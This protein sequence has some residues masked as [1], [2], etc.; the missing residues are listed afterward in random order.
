MYNLLIVDDEN[1]ILDSYYELLYD[2]FKNELNIDKCSSSEQA[3]KKAENRIDIL[4]TDILMPRMNGYE[5]QKNITQIWPKCRIIFLTGNDNVNNAIKAIRSGR[6]MMDYIL[7]HEDDEMLVAAVTRAIDSLENEIVTSDLI[8]D[9]QKNILLALPVLRKEFMM[10]LL[11]SPAPTPEVIDNKLE[12]Y[13]IELS[14]KDRLILLCCAI[15]EAGS[16]LLPEDQTNHNAIFFAVDNIMK[17]YLSH[18][19]NSLGLT[20]DQNKMIWFIQAKEPFSKKSDK[21]KIYHIYSLLD[22]IQDACTRIL[23][24]SLTFVMSR[25]T[26][27]WDST[28]TLCKRLFIVVNQNKITGDSII[29][30]EDV[31]SD[32]LTLY[33]NSD[34][35]ISSIM[36]VLEK[37]LINAESSKIEES[38]RKIVF[39]MKKDRMSFIRLHFELCSIFIKYMKKIGLNQLLYNDICSRLIEFKDHTLP[40]D[41]LLGQYMNITKPFQELFID[42]TS[43]VKSVINSVV[44]YIN[45]NLDGDL[46]LTTVSEKFFHSPSYLSKLFKRTLGIGYCKY[47]TDQRMKKAKSLLLSTNGKVENISTMTGFE[48]VSY[49]IKLFRKTYNISP[50][51]FRD[52]ELEGRLTK[53]K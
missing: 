25:S 39:L 18:N 13:Q 26:C 46:S 16:D 35:N 47:V 6:E 28:S 41:T 36:D 49:F 9:V 44:D 21:E 22:I 20:Y 37:A 30:L 52:K 14:Q 15:K 2:K 24:I 1:V 33:D 53:A 32:M 3:L 19:F 31:S 12:Q 50:Q 7:K 29:F 42:N 40:Y 23:K 34:N 51:E 5:L 27:A 45:G 11:R 43:N 38:L 10:D 8:K 17:E 48:S 4:I